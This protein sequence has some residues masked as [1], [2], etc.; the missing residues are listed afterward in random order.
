MFVEDTAIFTQNKN[1]K[2]SI[3][4][5]K[6]FLDKLFRWF[7]K[8]KLKFNPYKSET[9]IFTLKKYTNPTLIQINNQ[10]IQ[11]NSKDNSIKYSGLHFDEKLN[12]KI[13]IN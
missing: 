6:N 8:W 12:W 2:S 5:L 13:H 3:K 10:E 4:D 11:W 9:K 1:F 7:L